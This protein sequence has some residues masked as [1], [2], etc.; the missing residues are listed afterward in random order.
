MK[1]GVGNG[2]RSSK[3]RGKRLAYLTKKRG[4]M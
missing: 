4:K 1:K 3:L 2:G